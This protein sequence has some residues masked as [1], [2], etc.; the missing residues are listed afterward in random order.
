MGFAFEAEFLHRH[1]QV[2][3]GA[4][5]VLDGRILATNQ[6]NQFTA[7]HTNTL[8]ALL[9]LTDTGLNN[10]GYILLFQIVEIKLRFASFSPCFSCKIRSINTFRD[11]ISNPFGWSVR[12]SHGLGVGGS[13][14]QTVTPAEVLYI[15]AIREIGVTLGSFCALPRE[16]LRPAQ[17]KNIPCLGNS[18]LLMQTI[19]TINARNCYL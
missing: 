11:D 17:S 14:A 18:S 16:I 5:V 4:M 9:R 3:L 2:N 7:L 10:F 1:S 8:L 6:L 19:A 13:V 12:L 15:L